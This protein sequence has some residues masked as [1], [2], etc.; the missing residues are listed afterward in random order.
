[1]S[2]YNVAYTSGGAVR[3]YCMQDMSL[4]DALVQMRRLIE[5]YMSADGTPKPYPN[6]KGFYDVKE[7]RIV[8]RRAGV[9]YETL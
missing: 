8:V 1:M 2:V 3:I 5:K 7:P 6:G 9:G 4:I